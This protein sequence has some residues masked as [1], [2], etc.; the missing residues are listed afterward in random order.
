[1]T[2]NLILTSDWVSQLLGDWS[3]DPSNIFTILFPEFA[4]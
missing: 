4:K 2:Q 1:M 3:S